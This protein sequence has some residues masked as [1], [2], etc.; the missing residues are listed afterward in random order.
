MILTAR[1]T[2]MFD[3][4]ALSRITLPIYYAPFDKE[5][6][7]EVGMRLLQRMEEGNEFSEVRPEARKLWKSTLGDVNWNGHEVKSGKSTVL[8]RYSAI[9]CIFCTFNMDL[10]LTIISCTSSQEC[11]SCGSQSPSHWP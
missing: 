2:A 7:Q 11:T 4:A 5:T 10:I 3:E 1:H 9:I 8:Y 6:R